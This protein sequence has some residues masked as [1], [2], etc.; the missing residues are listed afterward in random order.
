MTGETVTAWCAGD[1]TGAL[2]GTVARLEEASGVARGAPRQDGQADPVA[3]AGGSARAILSQARTP[4]PTVPA[5]DDAAR[6]LRAVTLR[7]QGPRHGAPAPRR[8]VCE[9]LR[10]AAAI[11]YAAPRHY[12]PEPP[13]PV[14]EARSRREAVRAD[15]PAPGLA[16]ALAATSHRLPAADADLLA[17]AR[18]T[19]SR[20]L[21]AESATCC[22]ARSLANPAGRGRGAG[23]G[24]RWL[25]GCRQAGEEPGRPGSLAGREVRAHPACT[26]SLQA[27][28]PRRQGSIS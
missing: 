25:S 3:P 2:R 20:R 1:G 24:P 21:E 18:R 26:S 15:L 28:E 13:P 6:A 11:G 10:W 8:R 14:V 12:D 23:V 5:G 7:P 9:P 17:A 22:A 4:S 27:R 19:P 16:W